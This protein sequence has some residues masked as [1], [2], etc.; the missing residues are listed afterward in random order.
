[1]ERGEFD[2][3]SVVRTRGS[4][5]GAFALC[6][7]A[8][9]PG[10]GV[11]GGFAVRDSAGVT[12]HEAA[13]GAEAVVWSVAG[14][15][16]LRVGGD[17]DPHAGPPLR[18]RAG[19]L[20]DDGS[21]VVAE[22]GGG[23]LRFFT[24]DGSPRRAGGGGGEDPEEIGSTGFLQIVGDSVWAY[25]PGRWR[26]AVLGR[27]GG[28][29]R[30]VP[31]D[32]TPLEGPVVAR[33]V[34]ADGAILVG[35]REPGDTAAPD[36]GMVLER[37][38]RL[39]PDAGTTTDFGRFPVAASPRRASGDAAVD[40]DPSSGPRGLIAVHGMDWFYADGEALRIEQYDPIG[41]VEAVY[42]RRATSSSAGDD[43]AQGS[44]AYEGLIIDRGGD[45]WA[46]RPSGD[47]GSGC[48]DVYQRRPALLAEACLPE[49]FTVLDVA[50]MSILGILRD[51]LGTEHVVVYRLSKG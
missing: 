11:P 24:A 13:P 33:G 16:V 30:R 12:L 31:L 38:H 21:V 6:V 17:G 37:L 40:A 3:E 48:W 22:A 9:D 51:D 15:P 42:A 19:R 36:D 28:P 45:V 35:Q 4:W 26:I 39:D 7:A 18:V 47:D 50:G 20:F 46:R 10:D 41:Q 2:E 1:M 29:A 43:D 44:P 27:D 25:D 8:C 34:F 14:A 32:S 23:G 5:I 49:R